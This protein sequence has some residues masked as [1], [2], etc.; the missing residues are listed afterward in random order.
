VPEPRAG[1]E[2]TVAVGDSLW[3]IAVDVLAEH[4]GA[5]PSDRQVT[6]YWRSLID[7]NLAKLVDPTN[8]DLIFPGQ[9][10]TLPPA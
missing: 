6:P 8:P 1:D 7:A 5:P 3:S 4:M 10:F 9:V 2:V